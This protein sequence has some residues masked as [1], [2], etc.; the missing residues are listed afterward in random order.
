MPIWLYDLTK[1]IL[2]GLIKTQLGLVLYFT[3]PFFQDSD[4]KDYFDPY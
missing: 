2:L 1:F 4:A 3:P